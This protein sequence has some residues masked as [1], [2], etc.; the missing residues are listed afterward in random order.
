M[1]FSSAALIAA[2]RLTGVAIASGYNLYATLA[3]LG[4]ASR[5]G[6][7]V[8][9]P[10]VR[11]LENPIVIG[12][13]L[14]LYVAEFVIDKFPYVDAV[15]EAVHTLVRPLATGLLAA[16]ALA[17]F[18]PPS[19]VGAAAAGVALLTLAAHGAKAGLRVAARTPTRP[20]M[21]ILISILEDAAALAIAA[22][23]L[24]H[25]TAAVLV[26]ATAALLLVIAGPGLW[27][28]GFL[29]ILAF[30]ARLRGFFGESR[31]RAPAEMPRV[32]RPL[33]EPDPDGI[34]PPRAARAALYGMPGAGA[35]RSGWLVIEHGRPI[36]VYRALFSSRRIALPRADGFTLQRGLLLDVLELDAGPTH[37]AIFLFKDGPATEAAL[38]ELM[39]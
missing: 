27:R 32:L 33:I 4:V 25:A 10:G 29:G 21:R 12:S 22:A 19:Q 20:V 11:G 30:R 7:F 3:F 24:L 18:L 14:A 15:W 36:F 28:A 13:A 5:L 38:A 26:A 8:L 1:P 35:Y 9:P 17:G 34:H 23:A 39:A 6:W 2:G 16:L 31:W 37:Y